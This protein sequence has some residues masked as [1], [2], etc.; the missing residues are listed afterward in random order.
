MKGS[1]LGRMLILYLC[2]Y[3]CVDITL[4]VQRYFQRS[5]NVVLHD[6]SVK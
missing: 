1:A 5:G 2:V 6:N 4:P 3:V